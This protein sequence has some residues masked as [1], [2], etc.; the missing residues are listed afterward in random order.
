APSSRASPPARTPAPI[1][2]SPPASGRRSPRRSATPSASR[3]A[4]SSSSRPAS[5]YSLVLLDIR[6]GG[7][8]VGSG[9]AGLFEDRPAKARQRPASDLEIERWTPCPAGTTRPAGSC[10]IFGVGKNVKNNP[11]A[12]RLFGSPAKIMLD[13]PDVQRQDGRRGDRRVA[14]DRA[15]PSTG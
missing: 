3:R 14:V 8:L 5:Q 4:S 10:E 11:Y 6:G 9:L 2:R 15:R 12:S 7:G 1:R 13:G